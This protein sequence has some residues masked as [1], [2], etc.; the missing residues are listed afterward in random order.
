M[1]LDDTLHRISTL[2]HTE[3]TRFGTQG[4]GFYYSRLAPGQEDRPQRQTIEDMWLVTNRH[5]IIPK[6]GDV[7]Y[8]P[9]NLTFRLRKLGPSDAL[10]WEPILLSA[11]ELEA[12]A[13][14]HPDSSVDVAVINIYDIVTSRLRSGGEYAY[15]YFLH[16]GHFAG[17]NNIEVEASS[18]ILVVGY[19]RGFYDDVNL[20]PIL[21]SGIIASR[22]KASFRG[23]PY[24]LID[25]KLFPGS[26]GSVVISNPTDLVV[27]EGNVMMANEKQFAFLGVYSGEHIFRETP[28][29]VGNLT[30]AQTTGFDLGIVWYAELV[31]EIIDKGVTLSQTLTRRQPSM[32]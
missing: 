6:T 25:A 10:T 4:S 16:S 2:I 22:W 9:T 15:P 17:K 12:L 5:V 20:F 32:S 31:E 1:N 14:F 23:R 26:S 19:P 28:V 21:K 18:E 13:K 3:T 7:E 11:D 8:A 30:I 24:F 27:K 29:V